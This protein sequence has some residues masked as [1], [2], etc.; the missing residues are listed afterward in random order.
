MFY[1]SPL[2]LPSGRELAQ[3]LS[4]RENGHDFQSIGIDYDDLVAD[5]KVVV[6]AVLWHDL[7]DCRWQRTHLDPP[8][9]SRANGN[10]HA[11]V[12]DVRTTTEMLAN[13]G[14]LLLR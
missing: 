8:G 12:F 13:V 9:Q 2:T 5:Q 1:A 11:Q 6:S 10:R 3:V 14:S 7:D 4:R